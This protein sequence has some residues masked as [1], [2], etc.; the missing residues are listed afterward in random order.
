MISCHAGQ[1]VNMA[2]EETKLLETTINLKQFLGV[3]KNERK[4]SIR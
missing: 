4:S 2:M 3:L 1:N